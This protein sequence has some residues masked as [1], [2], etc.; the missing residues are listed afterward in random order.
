MDAASRRAS[1]HNAAPLL[2]RDK[3]D[4]IN[5]LACRLFMLLARALLLILITKEEGGALRS[6]RPRWSGI[7]ECSIHQYRLFNPKNVVM[8]MAKV[9]GK[10]KGIT[11]FIR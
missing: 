5:F 9:K 11:G 2:K 3:G 10:I 8:E 6:L 4:F 7:L 1:D